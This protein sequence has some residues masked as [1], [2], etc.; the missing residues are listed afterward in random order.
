VAARVPW[1]RHGARH[2]LGF[3]DQVAW[4]ACE[5]SKS[6][7]CELMRISWRTVGAICERVLEDGGA[8]RRAA[9]WALADR[10]R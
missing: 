8:L 2:T 1:A 6:A 9:R 7:I 3:E 10:H 5:T 4:L